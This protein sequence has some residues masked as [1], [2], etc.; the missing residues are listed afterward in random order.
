MPCIGGQIGGGNRLIP[1]K[2]NTIK[3]LPHFDEGFEIIQ[4]PCPAAINSV[5]NI[6]RARDK[7]KIKRI[8]ADMKGVIR[9]A[10]G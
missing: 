3:R 10:R 4:R 5:M 8:A 2:M 1:H 6:R 9:V 7:T